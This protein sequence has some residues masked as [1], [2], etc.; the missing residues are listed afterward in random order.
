MT[1]FLKISLQRIK[2]LT[3]KVKLLDSQKIKNRIKK[4][5]IKKNAKTKYFYST[6][7]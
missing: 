6:F 3:K 7:S 5:L 1:I 4:C 2:E